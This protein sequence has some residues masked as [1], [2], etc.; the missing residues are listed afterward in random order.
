M[1]HLSRS[2][3][4]QATAVKHAVLGLLQRQLHEMQVVLL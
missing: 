4:T 1:S 3:S 2:H